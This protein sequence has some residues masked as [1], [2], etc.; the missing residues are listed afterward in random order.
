M[1]NYAETTGVST[2]VSVPPL[3]QKSPSQDS[4]ASPFSY[5]IGPIDPAQIIT[6]HAQLS[7]GDECVLLV[8]VQL[9]P[10]ILTHLAFKEGYE[11]GYLEGNQQEEVW[12]F[13]KVLNEIYAELREGHNDADP[14]DAV[15]WT[16]GFLLGE[17]ASL[18]EQ[19]QTLA[20]TGLA[21]FAFLIP[22]FAHKRPADWPRREP[23]HP[24]Y[25]HRHVMKVYRERIRAYKEQGKS[26]DEA[27]RLAVA[28]R[29]GSVW[30]C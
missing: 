3:P 9:P 10:S 22:L 29:E 25:R 30:S 23:Y 5:V 17:L 2:I 16:L 6:M 18:A 15:P 28:K 4:P 8:P 26:F 1:L 14:A 27:Q 24:Y 21:H 11:C 19:D 12:T 20:L 7:T 13:P